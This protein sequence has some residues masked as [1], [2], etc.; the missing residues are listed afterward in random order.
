METWIIPCNPKFYDIVGA[1]S[2]L[3]KIDWRQTVKNVE[4]GDE[5]YVYVGK[6]VS[7][8]RYRCTVNKVDLPELEIDDLEFNMDSKALGTYPKYMELELLETFDE[9][10]YSIEVLRSRGLKG[11]IQG[12]RRAGDLLD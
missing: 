8:I 6:P 12:P 5:V 2:K 3:K 10:R 7:A 1:F 4:I 9:N 11:N